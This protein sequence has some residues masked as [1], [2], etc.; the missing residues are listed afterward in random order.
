MVN[1]LLWP[2]LCIVPND[3]EALQLAADEDKLMLYA[4]VLAYGIRPR[5]SASD[6]SGSF[7]V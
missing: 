7:D 4:V 3:Y 1:E 6:F 2:D 5:V